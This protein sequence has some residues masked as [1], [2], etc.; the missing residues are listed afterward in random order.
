MFRFCLYKDFPWHSGKT[1]RES[2]LKYLGVPSARN[3]HVK[4]YLFIRPQHQK[5]RLTSECWLAV[6]PNSPN[7]L[8]REFMTVGKENLRFNGSQLNLA[9]FWQAN[10]TTAA[11]DYKIKTY[12]LKPR[13]LLQVY[14]II[15]M[16][17]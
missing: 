11:L 12:V 2:K 10:K 7:Y 17:I 3:S 4:T 5:T 6:P 13:K 8:L 14:G 1:I 9:T 16:F 15:Y